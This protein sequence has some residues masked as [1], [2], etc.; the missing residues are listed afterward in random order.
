MAASRPRGLPAPHL[1]RVGR[2]GILAKFL[3]IMS[4]RTSLEEPVH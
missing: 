2:T 4:D 1:L 3:T